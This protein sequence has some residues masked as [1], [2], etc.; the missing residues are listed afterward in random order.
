MGDIVYTGGV[1]MGNRQIAE[2]ILEAAKRVAEAETW[3][4]QAREEYWHLFQ[5]A[6]SHANKKGKSVPAAATSDVVSANK[7]AP[8]ETKAESNSHNDSSTV[9]QRVHQCLLKSHKPPRRQD[10][11]NGLG[12]ADQQCSMGARDFDPEGPR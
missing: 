6:T 3:L 8:I 12:H 5:Q 11:S 2:K 4:A 1:I 9:V 7:E 10:H